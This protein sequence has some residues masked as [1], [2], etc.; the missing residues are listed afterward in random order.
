MPS[1]PGWQERFEPMY[2]VLSRAL[3]NVGDFLIVERGRRL[4]SHLKPD[5]EQHV[6]KAWLPLDGHLDLV[7]R[8][9]AV[10]ICGGPGLGQ[11]A[12]PR[13]YPLARPL[14]RI[15]VP[16]VMLGS[17]W[18]SIPGLPSQI[19]RPRFSRRTRRFF[20]WVLRRGAISVRDCVSEHV[21][22]TAGFAEVTMTGCPAWYDLASLG[23]PFEAP[24]ALRRVVLT[25]PNSR[26][27]ADQCLGLMAALREWLPDAELVCSLHRGLREDEFTG[28]SE[29]ARARKTA[30]RAEAL[31]Y[32]VVN[33]AYDVSKIAFYRECDLHVGYRVHAHLEF[34]SRRRPSILLSED[35]RGRGA[36]E[37]LGLPV[38]QA[39]RPTPASQLACRLPG[40][41][42]TFAATRVLRTSPTVVAEV[43]EYLRREAGAGFPSMAG[44]G[45]VIDRTYE[46]A[47]G[48]FVR[49][50]P[51]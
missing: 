14:E 22:R 51:D 50:I 12:Y 31:G 40:R 48:P 10:V 18:W 44:A 47:M 8:A 42:A 33:A 20:R 13:V 11:H 38:F 24:R 1:G 30:A 6:L 49:A 19:R 27:Y 45:D 25:T 23:Q 5:H 9:S 28:A 2:V 29:A 3:K 21:M 43:I 37:A 7:N 16:L 26:A 15:E 4:L 41:A 35:T 17:G 39:W 36:C 32:R 34:M 46:T